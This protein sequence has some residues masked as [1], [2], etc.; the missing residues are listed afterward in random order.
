MALTELQLLKTLVH[1]FQYDPLNAE[2]FLVRKGEGQSFVVMEALVKLA[3]SKVE[4]VPMPC[5]EGNPIVSGIEHLSVSV[6]AR[7]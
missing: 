3:H 6:H 7:Q 4:R 2:F 5:W 1:K